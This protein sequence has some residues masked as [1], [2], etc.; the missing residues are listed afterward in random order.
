MKSNSAERLKELMN[1]FGITQTELSNTTGIPK[2]AISMYVNGQRKPKSDRLTIIAEKYN[3]D[4]AWLMG[5]NVKMNGTKYD[6]T[7]EI[8]TIIGK[9]FS[10]DG[11]RL[12]RLIKIFDELDTETKDAY[13]LI[14]EKMSKK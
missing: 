5:A 3:V 14:G 7:E 2:S 8:G 6:D 9:L 12:E 10:E 1:H 11:D 13:I 4:E